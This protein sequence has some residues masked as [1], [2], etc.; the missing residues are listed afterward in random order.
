MKLIRIN[1]I[2][3]NILQEFLLKNPNIKGKDLLKSGYGVV[4]S[5]EM[6]GCFVLESMN[7]GDS[8]WLQKLYITQSE[9]K[10]LPVL[11]E[12]ILALAKRQEAKRVHVHSHQ[13]VVDILLEALQFSPQRTREYVPMNTMITGNWW[14]YQVS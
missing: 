9:T 13:P 1:Q 2:P 11:I 14:T 8:C 3:Y 12:S 7:E 6:I 5:D 10:K 4:K